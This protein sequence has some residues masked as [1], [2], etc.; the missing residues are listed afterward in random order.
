MGL[1]PRPVLSLA[2]MFGRCGLSAGIE[3]RQFTEV[4]EAECANPICIEGL[5]WWLRAPIRMVPH[6]KGSELIF[7]REDGRRTEGLA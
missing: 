4:K 1:P 7:C 3:F 6:T 5:T 2:A